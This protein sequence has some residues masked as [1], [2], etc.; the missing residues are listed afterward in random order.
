M[1]VKYTCEVCGKE[2]NTPEGAKECES[3]HDIAKR[4]DDLKKKSEKSI[5]VLVEKHIKTFGEAPFIELS[6]ESQKV[7]EKEN[8][9][10][11]IFE[12]LLRLIDLLFADGC[13]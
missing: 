10:N 13:N 12:D 9:K 2:F 4:R 8:D 11:S 3:N 6:D 1:K 5:A 7:I